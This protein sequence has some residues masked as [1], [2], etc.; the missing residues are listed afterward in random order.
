MKEC[1][2]KIIAGFVVAIVLVVNVLLWALKYIIIGSVLLFIFTK[3]FGFN[4]IV[5][6]IG[7]NNPTKPHVDFVNTPWEVEA[8]DGLPCAVKSSDSDISLRIIPN[9]DEAHVLSGSSYVA[10]LT[11]PQSHI[12]PD[13]GGIVL[14]IFDM[15]DISF[16]KLVKGP[17]DLWLVKGLD[18]D[19][20]FKSKSISFYYEFEGATVCF[21]NFSLDGMIKAIDSVDRWL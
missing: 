17:G 21:A 8:F 5:G 18:M 19:R 12:I 20:L 3:V 10:T 13:N 4:P 2:S 7:K 15:Q 9:T 14:V 11:P 6:C 1:L 16:H